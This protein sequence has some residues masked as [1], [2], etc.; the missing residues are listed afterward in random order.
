[1]SESIVLRDWLI[2]MVYRANFQILLD[3]R[4]AAR[5]FKLCWRL[6]SSLLVD[7]LLDAPVKGIGGETHSAVGCGVFP[8][9]LNRAGLLPMLLVRREWQQ[10][11]A[12]G[13]F[14]QAIGSTKERL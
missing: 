8:S 5:H 12:K 10:W 1:M 4:I 9:L 3:S 6:P 13:C 7:S 11:S 14:C 2:N